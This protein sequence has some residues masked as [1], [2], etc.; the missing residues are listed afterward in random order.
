M[1]SHGNIITYSKLLLTAVF[2]GGTFIAARVVMRDVGA[3]PAAFL[4]FALASCFLLLFTWRIEKG[5]P[6]LKKEQIVPIIMLGMHIFLYNLFFFKA[7]KIIDAGRAAV[8][9]ALN[10]IVIGMLSSL[11]FKEKLTA[12]RIIGLVVSVTGAIVV[13]S[14]GS[15]AELTGG[16][17]GRGELYVCFAVLGWVFYSLLGKATMSELSPLVTV[18]YSS[19]VGTVAL[20]IPAG[21]EGVFGEMFAYTGVAWLSIFYLGF[22]GTVV[23]FVWFY[24]GIDKIGATRASQFINFVPISA[25]LLA[26]IVLKEPI[27]VSLSIGTIL[28][29]SGVCLSNISVRK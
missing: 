24:E 20:S 9:V 29:C 25:V 4:R 13:V 23:G 17:F 26:F 22:F 5:L 3:F 15:A 21:I 12:A 2:W 11:F 8:I 7:L 6:R 18:T 1:K 16:G 10:P 28:V 19:L 27:T 14:R